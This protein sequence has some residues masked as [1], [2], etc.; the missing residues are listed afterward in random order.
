[1]KAGITRVANT[2]PRGNHTEPMLDAIFWR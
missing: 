1:V 2:Q